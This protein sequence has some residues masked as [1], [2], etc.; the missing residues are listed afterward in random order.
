[1]EC[2]EVP[3]IFSCR[4]N[5]RV[6]IAIH[7]VTAALVA[8]CTP[9]PAVPFLC[10]AAGL[11]TLACMC[12]QPGLTLAEQWPYC[13]AIVFMQHLA[14]ETA[15]C[16]SCLLHAGAGPVWGYYAPGSLYGHTV[17][18]GCCCNVS[19]TRGPA[20]A[21]AVVRRPQSRCGQ[22]QA[23]G[24]LDCGPYRSASQ[25]RALWYVVC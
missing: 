22:L 7:S 12:A 16:C 14:V 5:D 8:S 24:C 13:V 10:H 19:T 2:L 9:A 6:I 25:C 18:A 23:P 4:A 17:P 20:C 15:C 11:S 1:V 3:C 21:A